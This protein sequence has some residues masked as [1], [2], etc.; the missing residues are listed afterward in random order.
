MPSFAW[1]STVHVFGHRPAFKVTVS[2]VVWQ[3]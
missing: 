3:G 2:R 1:L